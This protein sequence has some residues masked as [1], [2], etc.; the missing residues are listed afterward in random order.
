[1]V[2]CTIWKGWDFYLVWGGGCWRAGL[3]CRLYCL[4]N[5]YILLETL[6]FGEGEWCACTP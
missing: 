4:E 5:Y 1:M 6:F 2:D 3:S